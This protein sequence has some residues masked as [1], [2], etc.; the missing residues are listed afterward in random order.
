MTRSKKSERIEAIID[1]LLLEYPDTKHYLIFSNPFELM[2]GTVLSAQTHDDAVNKVTKKLF[3]KYPTPQTLASATQEEVEQIL[4]GINY[5]RNKSKAIR[6]SSKLIFGE[7]DGE[8]PSTKEELMSLPGVG[9]KSANAILINGFGKVE[10]IV[11]DTHVIRLSL[12]MGLTK[13]KKPD[14]IEIDLVKIT[15]KEYWNKITSLMKDHGRAICGR[16]PKCDECV[17][18]QLC[19]KVGV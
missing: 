9:R 12:R 1:A 2:V 5:F 7:F 6:N 3:E 13:T 17:V 16:R 19:P 11:V 10:G 18:S 15:P 14:Q 8:V 4:S